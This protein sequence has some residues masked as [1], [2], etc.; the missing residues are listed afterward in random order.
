[1]N[2]I[3][4]KLMMGILLA[5]AL[6]AILAFRPAMTTGQEQQAEE[7]NAWAN[8]EIILQNNIFSRDRRPKVVGQPEAKPEQEEVVVRPESYYRLK[9]LV[10]EDGA[11]IAFI[12]DARYNNV[13][14]LRE[15]QSVARGTIQ[16]LTLDSLEYNYQDSD[17]TVTVQIGRDLE[18]GFG[19]VTRSDI[20]QWTPTETPSDA[21]ST[22]TSSEPATG[23]EADILEQ[24]RQRRQEQL[25]R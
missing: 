20:M 11:F 23:D 8:Y 14:Q 24:L 18:G 4:T 2:G 13:L 7:S 12:E 1:M 25:G 15:G 22:S 21:P 6:G 5:A 16:N 10:Q 19:T 9:G 3:G 17:K